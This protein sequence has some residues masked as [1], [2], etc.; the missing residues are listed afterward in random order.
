MGYEM[1]EGGE[2]EG[3]GKGSGRKREKEEKYRVS[4]GED[5]GGFILG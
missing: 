4:R 2:G 1:R 3:W 5:G